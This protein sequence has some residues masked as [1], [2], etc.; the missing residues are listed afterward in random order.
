MHQDL[1]EAYALQSFDEKT[2]EEMIVG[3]FGESDESGR[4]AISSMPLRCF[5]DLE[6]QTCHS[7]FDQGIEFLLIPDPKNFRSLRFL[8]FLQGESSVHKPNF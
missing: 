8:L 2:E 5:E 3:A 6:P 1:R 4:V 7:L